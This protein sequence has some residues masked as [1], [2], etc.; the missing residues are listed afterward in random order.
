MREVIGASADSKVSGSS[1]AVWCERTRAPGGSSLVRMPMPSARKTMS[2]L[3]ASAVWAMRRKWLYLEAA[4]GSAC[5]C[6]QAAA[7]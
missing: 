2:N 4:P 1:S 3:A 7:W 5:G 6:R